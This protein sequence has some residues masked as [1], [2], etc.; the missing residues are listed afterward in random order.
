MPTDPETIIAMTMEPGSRADGI[1]V[2]AET[3]LARTN[4]IKIPIL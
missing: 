3:I 1:G 4:P 2:A